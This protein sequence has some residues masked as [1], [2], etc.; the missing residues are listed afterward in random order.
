MLMHQIFEDVIFNI[1]IEV[2]TCDV[3]CTELIIFLR[4]SNPIN[5]TQPNP[6]N[7]GLGWVGLKIMLGW[8]GLNFFNPK[9]DRVGKIPTQP[10]PNPKTP[11]PTQNQTL[12]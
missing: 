11:T 6:K 4:I 1:S 7:I 8:V 9:Y 10:N 12:E 3:I 5:P 2:V